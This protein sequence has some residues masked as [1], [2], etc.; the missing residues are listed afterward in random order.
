M[1]LCEH[2]ESLSFKSKGFHMIKPQHLFWLQASAIA[3]SRGVVSLSDNDQ[4]V[5]R[6]GF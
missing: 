1:Y 6:V 5:V 4:T 2:L 3:C